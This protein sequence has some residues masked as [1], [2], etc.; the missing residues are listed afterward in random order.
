MTSVEA[1]RRRDEAAATPP[2]PS[3][4]AK[5][6]R[7]PGRIV[8]HAFLALTALVW[9]LPLVYAFYTS[10]R[11]FAETAEKGYVSLPSGL[12][13]ENYRTVFQDANILQFFWN[14][15]IITIPAVILT[16][17]LSSAIAFVLARY[18]FKFNI[19]MLILFTAGN[20]LPPQVIIT[21][22]FR[23]YLAI[24]L[25]SWLADSGM[26][27]NSYVG[28]IVIHIAFQMGFVTF[29]LSNYMK[30]FPVEITES[31]VVDGA[32]LW[33]Q[34]WRLIL[35]LS[36][37]PLA[38]LGTLLFTWIYNDFFWAVIL[39][40]DGDKRPITTALQNLEGQFFTNQNLIAAGSLMAAIPTLLVFVL[41]QKQ[42]V[43]GLTLG[44]T[45]G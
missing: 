18:S 42:F 23:M 44:S 5:R 32:G 27:L 16:L 41:L 12:S 14:T 3:G 7:R 20:L 19:A 39:M 8:L 28:L 6:Q 36:R 22:L 21:P 26:M 37:P 1:A 45:K 25:P 24:P 34:F 40:Q 31:A 43:R 11:P 10:L 4:E 2:E 15:M 30:T 35:P 13:L 38:A 17:L 33:T 29:V 9:L